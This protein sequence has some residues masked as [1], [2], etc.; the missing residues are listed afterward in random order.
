MIAVLLY[1]G[2]DTLH[3]A[4]IK[5]I[6]FH[7]CYLLEGYGKDALQYYISKKDENVTKIPLI[8]TRNGKTKE[9]FL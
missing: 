1:R 4:S 2:N 7:L 9:R 5:D 3:C 8:Q 6:L